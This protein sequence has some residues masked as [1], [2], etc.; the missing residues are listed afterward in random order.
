MGCRAHLP[1]WPKG[2]GGSM[3]CQGWMCYHRCLGLG[4]EGETIGVEEGQCAVSG[5]TMKL[6]H[7]GEDGE[8]CWY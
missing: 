8:Q 2:G 5:C 7:F 4:G 1:W 3:G 6:K